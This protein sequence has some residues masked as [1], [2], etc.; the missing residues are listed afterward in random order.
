MQD[1]GPYQAEREFW[2]AVHD[3][4][5]PDVNQL[6]LLVSQKVESHLHVLQ[7]VETHSTPLPRLKVNAI[8]SPLIT[9][10]RG[11]LSLLVESS[12]T[13]TEVNVRL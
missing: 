11:Q 4:L 7:H 8:D 13:R 5:R 2:V 3:V 12:S 10:D 1:D 9:L 6:N